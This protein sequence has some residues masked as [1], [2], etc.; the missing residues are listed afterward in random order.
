[1]FRR[2][3]SEAG[4]IVKK[5]CSFKTGSFSSKYTQLWLGFIVSAAAHQIGAKVG[6][7]A[8]QRFWQAIY[9]GIQSLGIMLEDGVIAIGRRSGLKKNGQ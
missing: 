5:L 2:P 6:M 8:D 4:R 1:M 9:F 3:C 7:F